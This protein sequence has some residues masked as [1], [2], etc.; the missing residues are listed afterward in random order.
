MTIPSMYM[1]LVIYS[2]FNM[3]DVSWG[4]RENPT[5]AAAAKKVRTYYIA[6]SKPSKNFIISLCSLIEHHSIILSLPQD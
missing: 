1:L 3:N 6:C 4:T 2:L 5:P